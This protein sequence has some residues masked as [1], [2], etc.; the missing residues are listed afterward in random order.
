MLH[1]CIPSFDD[2]Q[3]PFCSQKCGMTKQQTSTLWKWS[4]HIAAVAVLLPHLFY[5]LECQEQELKHCCYLFCSDPYAA[6][7]KPAL[8]HL[9]TI[10][11]VS[12]A[13]HGKDLEILLCAPVP[14]SSDLSKQHPAATSPQCTHPFAHQVL[15]SQYCQRGEREETKCCFSVTG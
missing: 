8:Y 9:E 10:V 11:R 13:V 12:I 4:T 5:S 6:A 2:D 15:Q 1:H 14:V 3:M 7:L